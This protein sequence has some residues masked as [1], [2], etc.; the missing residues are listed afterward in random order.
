[1]ARAR[2]RFLTA[3]EVDLIHET[4]LEILG[5]IG[6]LVRSPDV[7]R[8]L[9]DAGAATD[10]RTAV[11]RIP[12]D[13]VADALRRAPKRIRLCGR[14]PGRDLEVPVDGPPFISTNGLSV[15]MTDIETGARRPT[16]RADTMAFARLAD[17]LDAVSFVW[18]QVTAGDVPPAA[19][20][21][22]ETWV[23]LQNTEKHVQGDSVTA[24][25]ARTQIRVA[26]LVA[27]SEDAL[28]RRPLLSVTVCPIAPLS[29]ERG[30]VEAQV[31]FARAGLPV[32]SM[33]MSLGGM[34]SP[35]T[36]AGTIA[37]AN[38]ENL[39][40]LVI[41]QAAAPGAPHIY[42]SESTPMDPM[43]GT[44]SYAAT[45][46][47]LLSAGLGQMAERYGLPSMIGQWGVD[48]ET[49][50]IPVSFSEV[51]SMAL[52]TL[53]GGDLCSG[54][55]GLEAA[56]GASLEQ[57]VID[58][59]LWEH[60]RAFLRNVS[61]TPET[62]AVDV[63]E[64]VGHGNTFL[65]HPHTVRNFRREIF[66]RDKTR[67]GW[68]ATL[69]DRM[70]PDARRVAKRLLEDHAVPPLDR[71]LVRDGEAVLREFERSLAG[72]A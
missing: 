59:S 42:A 70:V 50:G 44:I 63:I 21:L 1:M 7:L 32:S 17:A 62:V 60:C 9:A 33:S 46:V 19:H 43:H 28:R 31:E 49:P 51:Y 5:R 72:K 10:E 14:D 47:P 37:N 11:A 2:L 25:D 58:A 13:V 29:F 30:A 4:S 27:G 8:L 12:E 16:T 15:Y 34:T 22:H 54:M 6:V 36:I 3:R 48:G 20:N 41:T 68:E 66:V 69:S 38:A 56:K 55:G 53:S 65:K 24:A 23:T 57:M 26:S 71:D 35:V 52:T 67:L 45:E 18:P 64:S 39:A 40:S 61:V